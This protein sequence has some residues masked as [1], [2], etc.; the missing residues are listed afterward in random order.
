MDHHDGDQE[1]GRIEAAEIGAQAAQYSTYVDATE[2]LVDR[3]AEVNRFYIALDL[4]IVGAIGLLFSDEFNG[5]AR[6]VSPLVIV[7]ALAFAGLIVTNNWRGIIAS[8]RKILASKFE[9]IHALESELPSRPYAD[10]WEHVSPGRSK[11]SIARF[12]ARLPWLFIVFFAIVL[13]FSVL[14]AAHVDVVG[15][16]RQAAA[17][18]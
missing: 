11:I 8:Q 6:L 3:R 14:Q 2:R 13:V 16:L 15:L 9:V 7:A 17:G 18:R 4:A 10:E 5:V 1:D 12:E